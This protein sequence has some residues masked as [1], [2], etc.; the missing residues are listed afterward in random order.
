M[1]TSL[2]AAFIRGI[3]TISEPRPTTTTTPP[4]R[5]ALWEKLS[6]GNNTVWWLCLLQ[7]NDYNMAGSREVIKSVHLR[8]Q[9]VM[10]TQQISQS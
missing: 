10:E 3:L 4:G 7:V 1:S 2:T 5:V 6:K 8:K 9:P